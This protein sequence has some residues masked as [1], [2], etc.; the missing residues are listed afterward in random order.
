MKYIVRTLLTTIPFILSACSEVFHD[1]WTPSTEKR[2]L[3]LSHQQLQFSDEAQKSHV[4]V[5]GTNINWKFQH[6][7]SWLQFSPASGSS[8]AN[9][10]V[11]VQANLSDTARTSFTQLVSTDEDTPR[12]YPLTVTQ[13]APA[14]YITLSQTEVLLE[15][16]GSTVKIDVSSNRQWTFSS[17]ASWLTVNRSGNSIVIAAEA[18]DGASDREAYVSVTYGTLTRQIHVT[19]RVA[20]I[21]ASLTHLEF[22]NEAGSQSVMLTADAPWEARC[23]QSW[24]DVLPLSGKAGRTSLTIQVETNSQATAR[25]GTVYI[26]IG[27]T[28]RVSIEVVQNGSELSITPSSLQFSSE[29]SSLQISIS[30]NT[31]WRL[32]VSDPSWLHLDKSTGSKA[33]SVEVRV[34]ANSGSQRSNVITLY[35]TLSGTVVQTVNV[36]QRTS[37]LMVTPLQFDFNKNADVKTLYI[38]SSIDWYLST[39]AD[40]IGLSRTSGKGNSEIDVTVSPNPTTQTRT[41][42]IELRNAANVLLKTIPVQQSATSMTVYPLDLAFSPEGDSQSFTIETPEEWSISCPEWLTAD[43]TKG[44]GNAIIHLSASEH[45]GNLNHEDMVY[46]MN[47]VGVVLYHVT[48]HQDKVDFAINPA[49]LSISNVGT[50]KQISVTSN[51]SWTAS[52]YNSWLSVTPES[53]KGNGTVSIGASENATSSDRSSFVAFH[54]KSGREL[55]RADITQLGSVLSASPSSF[56]F[57]VDG[58]RETLS[59]HANSDWQISATETWVTLSRTSGSGDAEVQVQVSPS[60]S[61]ATRTAQLILKNKQG[62]EVQRI[63]ITQAATS[64]SANPTS[65]SFG[66]Q[67]STQKLSIAANAAWSLSSTASWLTLSS[68]SGTGSTTVDVT[69]GEN[70]S[71]VSRSASIRFYDAA[72][73]LIQELPVTQEGYTLEVSLTS[74]D[75][76]VDASVPKALTLTANSAWTAS[77]SASWVTLDSNAGSGSQTLHVS[78]SPNE[79]SEERTATITFTCGPL[80]RTVTVRQAKRIILQ[81]NASYLS[82]PVTGASQQIDITSNDAWSLSCSEGWLQLSTLSGQGNATVTVTAPANSAAS[83]RTA[84]ILLRDA[85]DETVATIAVTQTALSLSGSLAASSFSYEGGQTTLTITANSGWRLTAPAW[86]ELSALSGT[87][88]AQVTVTVQPNH[89]TISRSDNLTLANADGTVSIPIPILQDGEPPISEY[90]RDLGYTFPSAGGPLR[91]SSF[92]TEDWSAVVVDGADWISLSPTS[93]KSTQ[94]LTITTAD[95]ASGLQRTGQ[96]KVTYGFHVYTC[97]VV[98]SGKTLS[99]T[100]SSVNFFAKGGESESIVVTADKVPTVSLNASWL[101]LKQNGNSFTLVAEKNNTNSSRQATVTI[102]LPGVKDSPTATVTVRQAGVQT[103]LQGEGYDNDKNWN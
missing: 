40:W 102:S 26:Y 9:V 16:A 97:P 73:S 25:T 31:P 24:I 39:S 51:V 20:G 72:G 29:A 68:S 3:G 10:A 63:A 37:D 69:V 60:T 33:G 79:S 74:L 35:N 22:S 45:A 50:A 100:T 62:E 95:N 83:V 93:G 103:G 96:I 89:S 14:P 76:E 70:R 48:V 42:T 59:V 2:M 55:G 64:Y 34:D 71:A 43:Y 88:N 41:G 23:S 65:F 54:S 80:T 19:Q 38:T 8:A 82:F 57:M 32:E 4:S 52:G 58:G 44:S 21:E 61:S 78:V 90:T 5:T 30:G 56:M 7:T 11:S 77:T 84:N 12:S 67:Q 101:T 91:V 75:F 99:L 27:S 87:G 86:A 17:S 85:K 6:N 15:G 66:N 47:S 36:V 18:N 13:T 94:E 53:G 28:N 46:V 81:V 49:S 98:Q 92:E 1:D